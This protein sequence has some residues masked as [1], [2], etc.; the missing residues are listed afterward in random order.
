M[1][2]IPDIELNLEQPMQMLKTVMKFD[3][4]YIYLHN[5]SS[6]TYFNISVHVTIF[7]FE[8]IKKQI[9]K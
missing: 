8:V 2:K 7:V 5:D 9:A 6:L 4:C 3:N 1:K